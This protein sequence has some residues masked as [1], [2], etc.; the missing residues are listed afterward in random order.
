MYKIYKNKNETKTKWDFLGPIFSASIIYTLP[1]PIPSSLLFFVKTFGSLTEFMITPLACND[2]ELLISSFKVSLKDS[3]PIEL[4]IASASF[5]SEDLTFATMTVLVLLLAS[6]LFINDNS[7]EEL[8]TPRDV[9]NLSVNSCFKLPKLDGVT[10]S[11]VICVDTVYCF[12]D[13]DD[14]KISFI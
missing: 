9:A 7:T 1:E 2:S 5:A 6:V 12:A 3:E 8:G 14:I 4:L 10:P 13:K 11:I